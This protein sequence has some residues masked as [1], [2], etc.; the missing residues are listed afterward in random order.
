MISFGNVQKLTFGGNT[1]ENL[2]SMLQYKDLFY[3]GLCMCMCVSVQAS[4][5]LELKLLLYFSITSGSS[6]SDIQQRNKIPVRN[7]VC[8]NYYFGKDYSF[9]NY[10]ETV[11]SY[12]H[13][14]IFLICS[15]SHFTKERF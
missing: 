13:V 2:S 10:N 4:E 11:I 15:F 6:E 9:K 14:E 1:L 7:T 8:L 5:M 3:V 12:I